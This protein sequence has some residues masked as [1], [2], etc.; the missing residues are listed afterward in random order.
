MPLLK[1]KTTKKPTLFPKWW[2]FS[3]RS[4][5]K[6]VISFNGYFFWQVWLEEAA[7][8]VALAQGKVQLCPQVLVTSTSSTPLGF[9]RAPLSPRARSWGLDA[10]CFHWHLQ[11]PLLLPRQKREWKEQKYSM[12]TTWRGDVDGP[13]NL[14]QSKTW[15]RPWKGS[16]Y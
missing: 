14:M 15:K 12:G 6:K 11:P 13:V 2:F 4:F 16:D 9:L 8:K 5:G 10:L 3:K 1:K 7:G